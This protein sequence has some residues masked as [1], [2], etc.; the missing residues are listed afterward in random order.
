MVL[1]FIPT[2]AIIMKYFA[3]KRKML[4]DD[5]IR[6]NEEYASWF[7]NTVGGVREVKLLEY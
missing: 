2:K 6:E 3:K 7:G 4:M 5:F 1:L